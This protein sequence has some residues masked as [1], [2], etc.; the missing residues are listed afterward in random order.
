MKYP[1]KS[2]PIHTTQLMDK[3]QPHMHVRL[4]VKLIQ[5]PGFF[6][7]F[8]KYNGIKNARYTL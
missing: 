7:N 1:A 8:V 4:I 6:N 3:T 5:W 2:D